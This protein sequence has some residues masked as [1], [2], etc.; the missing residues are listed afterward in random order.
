MKIKLFLV[1]LCGATF[2]HAEI[3]AFDAGKVDSKTP[4]GLTP[5]EKL[6]YENQ[7]RLRMLN[8]YYTN[9]TNK[10]NLAVENIEG[11]QSVTEGLNTQYS[12]VN[13]RLFSL[14]QSYNDFDSNITQEIQNLRKY[15]EENRK[16]QENNYQEIQKIL[17]EITDAI[18]KINADYI[19][20]DDM[21]QS[22]IF[23][24]SEIARVEKNKANMISKV[25]MKSDD[26]ISN[27]NQE[28]NVSD[29]ERKELKEENKIIVDESWKKLQSS[30]ILKQAIEEVNKNK[31][32]EAKSKFEYLVN[33]HYKPARSTF[34][35]GEIRYKQQDYAEALNFYK[36]SSAISTKGDYVPKLLYHTAISLDK[37]GD[38]KSANKFYKALKTAYPD[39]P[40]AKASP[41][42]K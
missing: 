39:S 3:S 30:E 9:L 29:S 20:K 36:K 21:N 23:F 25:E 24:Q 13:T 14:E 31:F 10:I 17:N 7:E 37:V 4:Y 6:Q 11:L 8:E 26:N 35:L 34:W 33:I 32:D 28:L 41:N 12:K 5:N 18:N 16:I 2:L 40:E 19:S 42:R 22:M 1:A 15:V 38:T 27:I